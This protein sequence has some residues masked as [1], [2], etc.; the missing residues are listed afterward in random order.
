MTTN[1]LSLFDAPS[2]NEVNT[3]KQS[4][5]V[6][7]Q[8]LMER[9]QQS[10]T[11]AAKPATQPGGSEV[12]MS[13]FDRFA[14]S[15]P[16]P[17][18]KA[19]RQYKNRKKQYYEQWYNRMLEALQ[20]PDAISEAPDDWSDEEVRELKIYMFER[21]VAFV[22]DARNSVATAC[23]AWDWIM[24]DEDY[25]FSFAR[26]LQVYAE[27]MNLAT[28]EVTAVDVNEVRQVLSTMAHYEK[29]PTPEFAIAEIQSWVQQK[30][31]GATVACDIVETMMLML[32][33]GALFDE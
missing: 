1:N 25:S 19:Q 31:L 22:I 28:K 9:H 33:Q 24:S 27:E 23:E 7:R 10:Q 2:E 21:H 20:V 14:R 13:M 32:D 11:E 4:I 3:H 29:R 15:F 8:S 12:M 6:I 16:V 26:C 18:E 5:D 30:E 17:S